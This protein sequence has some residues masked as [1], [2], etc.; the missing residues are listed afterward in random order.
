MISDRRVSAAT[1]GKVYK[2]VVKPTMLYGLE[3]VMLTKKKGKKARGR[4][5][6]A[7]IFVVSDDNEHD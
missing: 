1:K 6:D 4:V 5:E 3:A 2:T 7:V